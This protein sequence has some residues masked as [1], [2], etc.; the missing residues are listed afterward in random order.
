MAAP[1]L[2]DE[3]LHE[4]L[5]AYQRS[6]GDKAA[7]ARSLGLDRRTF[8]D[9]LRVAAKRVPGVSLKRLA[10][11]GKVEALRTV[12]AKMPTKADGTKRYILSSIQNNTKVWP[13][14]HNL[15]A[16]ADHYGAE[17]LVGTFTY[18]KSAYGKGS[19]KRGTRKAS[20]DD[21]EWYDPEVERFVSDKRIQ[22][23]PGLIWC[24]EMNILPT[25]T[26]PLQGFETYGGRN[27]CIFPH[28]RHEVRSIVS[29]KFEGTKFNYTTGTLG[30]R[31]YIQKRAG[32]RAEEAHVYG[33][34]IVEVKPSGAWYVR[35]L[36]AGDDDAIYDLNLRAQAGIVEEFDPESGDEPF[37]SNITWGDIHEI[38]LETEVRK[39]MFGEGGIL[40]TF[41]PKHQFMHDVLDFRSR[42]HHDMRDP[43]K[44]FKKHV[45]GVEDVRKEVRR[46]YDFLGFESRRPW[47]ETV[48][49]PS[50]HDE[51]MPRWLREADYKLDP[52]N[53]VFYLERQLAH[54]RAI[55]R[56]EDDFLDLADA[57]YSFG[58]D[59]LVGIRFLR[60]DQDFVTNKT[61]DFPGIEHG[62]HGDT[63]ANL[64]KYGR[65]LSIGHKHGAEVRGHLWTAGISG[66]LDQGYN[67]GPSNWS[68]THI[69]EYRNGRRTLVTMWK[70][71]YR[72]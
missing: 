70:G 71:D 65:P 10:A 34:L 55:A 57:L 12:K 54:Y 21:A 14:F 9:R 6:G 72:G 7:A 45:T 40:D 20:D 15:L 31:N 38:S 52:V 13:G 8:T 37:V 41:R 25:A 49:V 17:V 42:N 69:F 59:P 63:W 48:V 46:V 58:K 28:T 56:G 66:A 11:G 50:N 5:D 26:D 36:Q 53:A 35:Q 18:N 51:A 60:R 39:L 29:G 2:P 16:L 67:V 33:G 22:L 1:R 47:C 43:H 30:Q 27:S 24:G 68:Q 61:R 44:M 32:L 23:A 62:L 19:T 4:A 3:V 64:H